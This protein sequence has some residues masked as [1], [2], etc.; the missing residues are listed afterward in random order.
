[1]SAAVRNKAR[2][3]AGPVLYEGARVA[4]RPLKSSDRAVS[5][6]WRNDPTIRDNVLGYRFPVTEE[7]EKHWVERVLNDQSRTRLV[8]AIEDRSDGRLVGFVYLSDID[9]VSQVAEFGILIG[10]RERQGKGLGREALALMAR[11]AFHVLNLH[12]I[13]LR[14]P[15]YNRRALRLYRRFGFV[16]EGRLRRHVF[17]GRR[18]H[19]VILMGLLRHEYERA[20][21]SG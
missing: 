2:R 6:A 21:H 10:E 4:L 11:H 7:M 3:A 13:F 19:D 17:L 1:M 16:E 12:R 9:W 8:L 5:V 14:V 18:H 15:R 20:G